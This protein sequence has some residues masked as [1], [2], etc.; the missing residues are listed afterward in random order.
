M[1]VPF[2]II[3]MNGLP[4]KVFV[5]TGAKIHFVRQHIVNGLEAIDTEMEFYPYIGEFET[6][7]YEIP[8]EIAGETHSMRTGV[9][10]PLLET[11]LAN[12]GGIEG[13]LGTEIFDKYIVTIEPGTKF[14]YLE[15]Y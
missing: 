7:V 14:M 9:L 1:D 2:T 15:R 13:I 10:P 6:E 5:D 4:Q 8:I 12:T 11:A 3:K